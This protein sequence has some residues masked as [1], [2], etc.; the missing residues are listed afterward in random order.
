MQEPDPFAR[1][2]DIL[3]RLLFTGV[4]VSAAVLLAGLAVFLIAGGTIVA[5]RVLASGLVL[6]M[7]TPVL[8]VVVSVAEYVRMRDWFFVCTTLA[9]LA[10]LVVT[11]VY[12]LRRV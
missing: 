3:G 6:L 11:L 12:A 1:L 9:V 2:E 7:A 10:Q 4:A 5:D 8:R